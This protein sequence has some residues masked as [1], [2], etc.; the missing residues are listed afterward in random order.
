[1]L[2]NYATVLLSGIRNNVHLDCDDYQLEVPL[3]GVLRDWMTLRSWA[4][5][6]TG[7]TYPRTRRRADMLSTSPFGDMTITLEFKQYVRDYPSRPDPEVVPDY[8]IAKQHLG[9][10]PGKSIN[11]VDDVGKLELAT[12]THVAFLLV[13][14]DR[15]DL[16]GEHDVGQFIKLSKLN[17]RMWLKFEEDWPHPN[18]PEHHVFCHLWC[19]PHRIVNSNSNNKRN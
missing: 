17:H 13:R 4:S 8:Q 15:N 2:A 6:T 18:D 12:S 9:I 1:M 16:P 3:T 5:S 19:R 7:L 14:F 11:G 10:L